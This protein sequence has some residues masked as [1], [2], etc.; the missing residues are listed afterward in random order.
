MASL[1]CTASNTTN[2][3]RR[4]NLRTSLTPIGQAYTLVPQKPDSRTASGPRC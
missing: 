4:D 3:L 2:I 1:Q